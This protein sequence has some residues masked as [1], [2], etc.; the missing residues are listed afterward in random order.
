[1]AD[2]GP[3]HKVGDADMLRQIRLHPE[4]FVTAG[5]LVP[6]TEYD[7]RQGVTNRLQDL[8]EK[9]YLNRRD[10]GSK[11]VV[12]WLTPAGREKASQLD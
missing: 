6:R 10:V 11:A 3:N 2:R 5:D 1:M 12:Y 7:S 4:P 8:V 9:N